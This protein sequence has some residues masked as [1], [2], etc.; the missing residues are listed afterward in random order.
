MEYIPIPPFAELI[1][2]SFIL[3]ASSGLKIGIEHRDITSEKYQEHL[4]LSSKNQSQSVVFLSQFKIGRAP[5]DVFN[6]GWTDSEVQREWATLTLDAIVDKTNLL[7]KEHYQKLDMYELLLYSN[8]YLPNLDHVDKEKAI[9]YL[10]KFIE[11][12]FSATTFKR[13]FRH[14]SFIYGQD[15]WLHQLTIRV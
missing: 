5:Q 13:F 7:N 14:I 12:K 2:N 8:T 1:L 10:L 15:V 6:A 9:A 4:S 3:S 11:E